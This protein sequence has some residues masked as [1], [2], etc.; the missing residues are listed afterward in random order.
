MTLV[1]SATLL[2]TVTVT[3]TFPLTFR[4]P[5][6]GATLTVLAMVATPIV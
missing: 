2:V 1:V 3:V 6:A 5:A 4:E